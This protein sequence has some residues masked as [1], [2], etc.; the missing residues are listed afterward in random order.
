MYEK[1][2]AL[3]CGKIIYFGGKQPNRS[4]TGWYEKD[5]PH[6]EHTYQRCLRVRRQ[7]LEKYKPEDKN[8]IKLDEFS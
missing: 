4:S 1:P 3:Q 5:E 8:Q 6:F 7:N 2:C